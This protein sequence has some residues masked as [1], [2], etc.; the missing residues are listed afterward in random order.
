MPIEW[1]FARG[2]IPTVPGDRFQLRMMLERFFENAVDALAGGPG[3]IEISTQVD[4]RDWVVV[5]IHDTGCGMSQEVQRRA[6]EPFFTTKEDRRG[7]GLTIAQVIWRRHG[8][9]LFD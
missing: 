3:K 8:G 6:A 1:L 9:A 4:A 2:A 7:V 5:T